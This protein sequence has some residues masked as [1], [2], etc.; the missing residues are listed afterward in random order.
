MVLAILKL[1][2]I[3][4]QLKNFI[5]L[6][7]KVYIIYS[8]INSKIGVTDH[9]AM[10][11]SPGRVRHTGKGNTTL[12]LKMEQD[13]SGGKLISHITLKWL[14]CVPT[15]VWRDSMFCKS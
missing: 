9:G 1:L 8:I 3:H 10:L 7:F 15:G 14:S 6:L 5:Q 12:A 13:K 4:Y 11:V 2:K